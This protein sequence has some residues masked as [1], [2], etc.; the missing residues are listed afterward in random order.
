MTKFKIN[1]KFDAATLKKH[2]GA[3]KIGLCSLVAVGI[4]FYFFPGFTYLLAVALIALTL[5]AF[6][7]PDNALELLKELKGGR[8]TFMIKFR[9]FMEYGKVHMTRVRRN[10]KEGKELFGKKPA[11]E[12]AV[13]TETPEPPD[14]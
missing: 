10:I 6:F 8:K 5:Y 7:M 3:I 1:L 13:E 4:M 2:S 11:A 14:A 9:E 12:A